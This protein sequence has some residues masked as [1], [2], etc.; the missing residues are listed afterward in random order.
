[1]SMKRW[2]STTKD[3][4]RVPDTRCTLA[5]VDT[6]P[7]L[8]MTVPTEHMIYTSECQHE[9]REKILKLCAVE[10]TGYQEIT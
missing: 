3:T 4:S 6:R 5:R 1:M 7:M 9:G 10:T 2:H 8:V